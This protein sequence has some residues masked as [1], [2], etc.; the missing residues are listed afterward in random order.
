MNF[1]DIIKFS[2]TAGNVKIKNEHETNNN[3]IVKR[4]LFACV[5]RRIIE[6]SE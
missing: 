2:T 5:R 4:L 1:V 3:N 6:L